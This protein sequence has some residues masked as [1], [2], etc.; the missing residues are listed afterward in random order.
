MKYGKKIQ[1]RSMG[2]HTWERR[3]ERRRK[4]PL[5]AERYDFTTIERMPRTGSMNG[6]GYRHATRF[7]E[8]R[9]GQAWT[10]VLAEFHAKGTKLPRRWDVAGM[11]DTQAKIVGGVVLLFR[12]CAGF[13]PAKFDSRYADLFVHPRTGQLCGAKSHARKQAKALRTSGWMRPRW[14]DN[15]SRGI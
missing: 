8:S 1:P 13:V 11:V 10:K 12:P 14:L 6:T 4:N 9:I 3:G 15:R 5:R 2:R 7:F